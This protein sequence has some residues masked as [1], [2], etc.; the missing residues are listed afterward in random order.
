MGSGVTSDDSGEVGG[1]YAGGNLLRGGGGAEAGF[2]WM[3]G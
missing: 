3:T 1:V 2:P